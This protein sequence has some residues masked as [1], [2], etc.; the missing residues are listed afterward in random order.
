MTRFTPEIF[1]GSDLS[2]W[3]W[4]FPDSNPVS[5]SAKPRFQIWKNVWFHTCINGCYL[6]TLEYLIIVGYGITV[7]GQLSCR[8]S[9][10]AWTT[11]KQFSKLLWVRVMVGTQKL[12]SKVCITH[13]LTSA[14]LQQIQLIALTYVCNWEC[15]RERALDAKFRA[16]V[17]PSGIKLQLLW[18]CCCG[19]RIEL[20]CLFP[21]LIPGST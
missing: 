6:C 10:G 15:S 7:L 14:K 19:V 9:V 1:S 18:C 17:H 3:T 13:R 8:G 16:S 11:R 5:G 20:A 21:S 2:L 4:H 12:C